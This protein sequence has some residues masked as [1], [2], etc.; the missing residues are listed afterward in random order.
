MENIIKDIEEFFEHGNVVDHSRKAALIASPKDYRNINMTAILPSNQEIPA[1][2]QP[3]VNADVQTIN[4][5]QLPECVTCTGSEMESFVNAVL[6]KSISFDWEWMYAQCKLIDGMPSLKGTTFKALLT[7]WKNIGFKPM[8]ADPNDAETIALYKIAGYVEVNTDFQ[9]LKKA[10][11]NYGTILMGFVGSNPGWQNQFVRAPLSGETTWQHSVRGKSYVEVTIRAQNHWGLNW[12]ENGDLYNGE[13]YPPFEAWAILKT[14]PANWQQL[15]P[16]PSS[17][18]K[19]KFTQNLSFGMQNQEVMFLQNC[20]KWLGCMSNEI[21]ITELF[22]Q[23]TLDAVKLYQQRMN[24]PN[25]GFVGPITIA[26]LNK[27]FSQ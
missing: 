9:S 23:I 16:Q 21:N 14:L 27:D 7:V 22:G 6:G 8:N 17:K 12:G 11:Y 3:L 20:L 13:E 25:T 2:F 5:G 26:A 15:L 1:E 18:P 24:I 10:I 19:Y 4:Q